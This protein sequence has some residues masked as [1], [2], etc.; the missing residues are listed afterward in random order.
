MAM[1]EQGS[2]KAKRTRFAII[3]GYLGAGKTTL[4][5]AIAKELRLRHGKSTAIVTND[6][7]NVLVDTQ[8][9][10]DA[11]FDVAEVLGGCF[12]S[13]FPEF[14]KNARTLVAMGRPDVIL[15][16]PIG[17]ST[18]VLSSVVAPLRN[19]YPEEFEVAPLLVVFDGTRANE[20]LERPT[21]FGLGS[22][23]RIIPLNQVHDAEVILISKCDLMSQRQIEDVIERIG[24]E[25][26]G[27]EVIPYSAHNSMNLDKIVDLL[28]SSR[29]S[30][31]LP[32][33][34]DPSIF[35]TE[36]A[37][38]GWYNLSGRIQATRLDL[39]AFTTTLL[40]QVA[41]AFP[42]RMTGHVKVVVSSPRVAVKIGLVE[43][44]VQVEGLKGS[45]FLEGEGRLVINARVTTSPEEMKCVFERAV[46][47]TCARFE[48]ELTEKSISCFAPRPEKPDHLHLE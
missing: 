23:S 39:S 26:P 6:Q 42:G 44:Q 32:R 18:N 12:C 10:K 40:R 27:T 30:Q 22:Q 31:K 47:S 33:P 5:T 41:E 2:A 3:G 25:A 13:K 17:T 19:L 46:E 35:A 20:M 29:T 43:G 37:S 21:G 28:V 4:A 34:D 16:E 36:K 9:V 38:M 8:Y 1:S 48:V 24:V 7:G 14:V 15:A 45:R 11:G